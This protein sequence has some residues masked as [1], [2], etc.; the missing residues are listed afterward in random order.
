VQRVDE[1]VHLLGEREQFFVRHRAKELAQDFD[2]KIDPE[3]RCQLHGGISWSG[4]VRRKVPMPQDS[5]LLS[6]TASGRRRRTLRLLAAFWTT[7]QAGQLGQPETIEVNT[8]P[9]ICLA[10]ASPE[11]ASIERALVSRE[12][13]R[14]ISKRVS[15]SP[16]GLHGTRTCVPALWK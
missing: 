1:R 4:L 8:V 5:D 6:K 14:N 10:C 2:V 15:I 3:F 12:P 16:A 9:R 13:L 7:R 11:R